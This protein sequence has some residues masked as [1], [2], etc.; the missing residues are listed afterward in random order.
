REALRQSLTAENIAQEAAYLRAEGQSSFERPYG[1]AWLLQVAAEFRESDPAL[2]A[3][4]RSL[5]LAAND[6]LKAWL[7]KLSH[8]VRSGE[9]SQTA[10]ALG[11]I[12]DSSTDPD[13]VRVARDA[14]RRFFINDKSCPLSYEPSGEDFLSPCIAVAEVIVRV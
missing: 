6:R 2:S 1:L 11:L 4:L 7:P 14:A 8:P 5:E 13:L 3:N 10:F 12:I 9:H